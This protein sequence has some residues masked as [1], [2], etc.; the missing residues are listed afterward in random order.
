MLLL[1]FDEV[2]TCWANDKLMSKRFRCYLSEISA[3]GSHLVDLG[4]G[5]V[6]SL[7]CLLH[8]VLCLPQLSEVDVGLLLLAE[9]KRTMSYSLSRMKTCSFPI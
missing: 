6:G 7:L 2:V 5:N 9:A 8:L 3:L 4:L 1:M